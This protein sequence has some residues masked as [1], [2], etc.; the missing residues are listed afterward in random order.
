VQT[1]HLGDVYWIDALDRY[2]PSDPLPH[3][4]VVLQRDE[5]NQSRLE[6]IV[7]CALTSNVRK[8]HEP[9]TVLLD[10]GEAGLPK[11][12]VVIASQVRIIAKTSLGARLG[13]LSPSRIEQIFDALAFLQRSFE[14]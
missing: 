7:V 13:R 4:Y 5:L 10:E 9:G 3:P 8:A 14:R 12:S 2:G 1:I 11:R 6:T